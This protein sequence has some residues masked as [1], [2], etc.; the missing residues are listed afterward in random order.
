M[1]KQ[2]KGIANN[3]LFMSLIIFVFLKDLILLSVA[4]FF[5]FLTR[6]KL[7]LRCLDKN[8]GSYSFTS[9]HIPNTGLIY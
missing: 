8:L 6:V 3:S 7:Y 4:F 1:E 9:A 2:W 5:F